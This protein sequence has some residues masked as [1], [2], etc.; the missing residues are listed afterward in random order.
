MLFRSVV[1]AG[2]PRIR[3]RHVDLA[4]MSLAT[5]V[6][7]IARDAHVPD[8]AAV[9]WIDRMPV[10]IRHGAKIDRARLAADAERLLAGHG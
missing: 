8:V 10:D 9:L 7:A 5:R 2:A 1:G 3:Q 6:R 4:E